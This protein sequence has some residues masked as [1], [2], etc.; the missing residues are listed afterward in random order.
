MVAAIMAANSDYSVFFTLR[1]IAALGTMAAAWAIVRAAASHARGLWSMSTLS[2]IVVAIFH[3][4]ALPEVMVTGDSSLE[5]VQR[6]I[7]GPDVN[8]AVW[9]V[10]SG[11]LAFLAGVLAVTIPIGSKMATRRKPRRETSRSGLSIAFVG[12]SILLIFLAQWFQ[13]AWSSGVLG[14]NYLT[15]LSM[16]TGL[17][18]QAWYYFIGIGLVLAS[19]AP[20]HWFCRIGFIAFGLFTLVG[21]PLGLRGEILFPLATAA[22]VLAFRMK[23]PRAWITLLAA[24]PLLALTAAVAATRTASE[25]LTSAGAQAFSPLSALAEMGASLSVMDLAIRWHT[26]MGIP[27]T[28]GMHYWAPARDAFIRMVLRMSPPAP[29]A[30]TYM[31][32]LVDSTRGAIGGSV[33][34]SGF[35]AFSSAGVVVVMAAWGLTLGLIAR[36]SY[37]R[38]F[39]LAAG[40][41]LALS[42]QFHIRNDWAGVPVTLIFGIYALAVAWLLTEFW[43]VASVQPPLRTSVSAL[44]SRNTRA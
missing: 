34:A 26:D 30:E 3:V 43:N 41:I 11:I 42:F 8:Q 35:H 7:H 24:I 44:E 5:S 15:Y 39:P 32:V 13:W 21:F 18:L 36:P 1:E 27:F 6:W 16:S 28:E 31:N 2:L 38:P 25:G 29:T 4:G 40:A 9:L 33:I 19:S 22:G 37:P 14:G 23:M 20:H 12:T 17:S 10:T